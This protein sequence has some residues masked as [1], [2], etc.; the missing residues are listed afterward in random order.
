M[1]R[2]VS[3]HDEFFPELL[4][5][6]EAVQDEVLAL[7]EL[8]ALRGPQLGRPHCDTLAGSRYPNMKEL[9]F[10]LLDGVWRVAFAFDPRRPAILLVGASKSGMSQRRFYKDLIRVADARFAEHLSSLDSTKGK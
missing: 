6:S 3:Y 4:A 1:R 8:L 10:S 5:E 9:R 2:D 7:A